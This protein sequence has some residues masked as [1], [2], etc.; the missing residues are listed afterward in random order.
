MKRASL[1]VLQYL[2]DM[3][4]SFQGFLGQKKFPPQRLPKGESLQSARFKLW[5]DFLVKYGVS[6]I[7]PWGGALTLGPDGKVVTST[8]HQKVFGME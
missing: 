1:E 3:N 7:D 5:R 8:E 2:A 4:E 6:D